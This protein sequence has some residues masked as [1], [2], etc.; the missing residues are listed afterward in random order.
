MKFRISRCTR[1]AY[2]A[3]ALIAATCWPRVSSA[4]KTDILVLRNGDRI[5]GEVKGLNRGKLEY[6][7]DD[8]G[9]IFIEWVKVARLTS[10]ASFDAEDS[11]GNRYFGRLAPS[12]RDDRLVFEGERTDT[13]AVAKVIGFTP[14]NAT[15]IERLSAY[16]DV[17]FSLAK[18]NQA[19]TFSLAGMGDYR[20]PTMGGQL[21]YD[22]YAQGQ[23]TVPTTTRNTVRSSVSWF[24]QPRWSA[25]GIAQFEQ[26]DELNL[27]HRFTLGAAA[28]RVIRHTNTNELGLGIGLAGTQERFRSSSGVTENSSLEGLVAANWDVFHFD[29]P[30]L[31]FST[32]LGTFPSFTQW[33]RVRGQANFRL[34]YEL[35][36]DFNTGIRFTDTFDSRPPEGATKN[37]YTLELT[38]GWSYHR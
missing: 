28:N 3:T 29:S 13:V 22:T 34:S 25:V 8:A 11:R 31:D 26:N 32:S 33:K 35:V 14:V 9:T 4:T 20:G 24:F 2:L 17:G 37:D 30:K 23:E 18:A 6:S 21:S 16:L 19:T 27:D 5:T 36:K 10:K 7:T 12:G 38:I 1:I 15:F